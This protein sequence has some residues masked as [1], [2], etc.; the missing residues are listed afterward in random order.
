M[1]NIQIYKQ[2]K[3]TKKAIYNVGKKP[4]LTKT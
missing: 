2:E 4:V 3:Y 1:E